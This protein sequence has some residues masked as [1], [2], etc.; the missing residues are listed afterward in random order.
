M[1]SPDTPEFLT[2]EQHDDLQRRYDKIVKPLIVAD[3]DASR[4]SMVKQMVPTVNAV[5]EG[6]ARFV[7]PEPQGSIISRIFRDSQRHDFYK[8]GDADAPEAIKDRNGEVVLDYCRRCGQAEAEIE[9][10]CPGVR[11]MGEIG[12]A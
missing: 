10:V 8:T 5:L 4:G 6:D 9:A 1:P 12:G 2:P 11:R 7:T 3:G